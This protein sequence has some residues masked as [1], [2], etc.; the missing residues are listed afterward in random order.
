MKDKLAQA[1][2]TPSGQTGGSADDAAFSAAQA[3][4]TYDGY[5]AY[6]TSYPSGAHVAE[7]QSARAAVEPYRVHVCNKSSRNVAFAGVYQ[8]VGETTNWTHKG[9]WRV[10]PGDCSYVF[11]TGNAYFA[12]RAESLDDT[13][14]WS[15][16]TVKLCFSNPGPFEFSIPNGAD[17]PAGSV[18]KTAYSATAASR[19][20]FTWSIG[21]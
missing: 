21:N 9:W 16:T 6:L 18:T 10:A 12:L 2:G 7:A 17:C 13:T 1:A 19:G 3:A 20:E 11:D 15:G 5:S 8:P 4:N 14:T